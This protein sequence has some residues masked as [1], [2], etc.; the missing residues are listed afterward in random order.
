L[1]QIFDKL[2][3]NSYSFKFHFIILKWTEDEILMNQLQLVFIIVSL[4]SK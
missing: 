2:D 3:N 4:F 1:K